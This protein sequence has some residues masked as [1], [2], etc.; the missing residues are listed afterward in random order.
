MV[1]YVAA[2]MKRSH[3]TQFN[4]QWVHDLARQST[5]KYGVGD[6]GA[7]KDFFRTSMLQP[8]ERMWSE[9]MLDPDAN[10]VRTTAEG[11]ERVLAS[12]DDRPWA[13]LADSVTLDYAA[14]QRSDLRVVVEPYSHQFLS[15]AVPIGSNYFVRLNLAILEMWETGEINRLRMKWWNPE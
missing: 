13:F 8:Y 10:F 9:M 2:L 6:S 15:M 1:S 4:I 3:A 11:V 7:I 14:S 5:V 12:T